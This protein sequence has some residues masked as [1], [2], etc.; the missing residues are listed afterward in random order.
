M[1]KEQRSRNHRQK[2]KEINSLN[3]DFDIIQQTRML[4]EKPKP[5][6]TSVVQVPPKLRPVETAEVE[7]SIEQLG[8]MLADK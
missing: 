2:R 1:G 6:R 8:R 3:A 7:A 5:V 4:K